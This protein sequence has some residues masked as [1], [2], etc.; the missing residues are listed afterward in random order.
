M[1][2]QFP[3]TLSTASSIKSVSAAGSAKSTTLVKKCPSMRLLS[4]CIA[5][6]NAGVP[7]VNVPKKDNCVGYSGY[8]LT[9]TN[10]NSVISIE[11]RFFTRNSEAERWILLTTRLPSNTTDGILAKSESKRTICAALDAASLPDAIAILQS[12]SFNASTSLTPSP[13]MA[14]TLPAF[15]SAKRSFFFC[16][17]DTL[18]N[19]VYT[20]AAFSNSSSESCETSIYLSASAIPAFFAT[21]AAALG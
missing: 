21:A 12:A 17:G 19:T 10:V 5:S 3:A 7:M 15:L 20:G 2:A 11:N 18:P 8:L 1:P 16:S 9:A 6:K 4:G 13:V 14:T